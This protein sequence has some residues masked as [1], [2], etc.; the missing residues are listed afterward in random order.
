MKNL[1]L[2]MTLLLSAGVHAADKPNMIV[3][4]CDDLGYADVGFNGCKDIP[5]PNIDRIA[6]NG[7][8]CTSGYAPYSVCGPSRAGLITGRYGQRFGFERNP[9]YDPNN[10]IEGLPKEEK[11]FGE[12]LKPAGY[13]SG[14]VGKWHM[15]AHP[16]NHP[17][18]RGFD[19]F[20]GH[21]GGGHYY[22]PENLTIQDSYT[23]KAG[24][25]EV[26]STWTMKNHEA[27]PPRKYLTEEFSD[28]AVEFVATSKDKPFFLFLSYNAPHGPLQATEKYLSRFPNLEGNRQIYAAMVSA[29]DDGVGLL[30][31]KLDELKLTEDTIVFFMSDNGGAE[32]KYESDNGVLRGEKSSIWEG[33]FR[34]PYAVQWKG[35]LPAG[36]EYHKPVSSLD[37]MGT[38]VELAGAPVDPARPLDGVNLIPY[39]SGKNSG[40]PHEAIY[41]RKFDQDKYAIRKGDY[42][43]MIHFK[44]ANPTLYN[45]E[46]DIGEKNDIAGQ[47]PEKVQQLEQ[48]RKKWDSEL[49][50][51]QFPGAINSPEWQAQ[52]K[53]WKAEEAREKAAKRWDWFAALDADR[54]G[55]VTE[56]EWV[57]RETKSSGSATT[58][59]RQKHY[60]AERDLNGNGT[61]TR[62][63]LDASIMR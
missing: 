42:K 36:T 12:V 10:P 51:P 53:Q 31:D 6:K 57:D 16:S 22:L 30:L 25:E 47:H 37:V 58:L 48:M 24:W 56:K 35:V 27:I 43:L 7:V 29:V 32:R 45:L 4:L 59:E 2:G 19:Y 26:Y 28:A 3:V 18:N 33:G 9:Y 44:G 52:I 5:T 62:E 21:L 60:F 14:I 49:I 8:K 39:L 17:L 13:R 50:E 46:K 1:I 20:Y 61:I 34:V 40:T 54:D 38:I 23:P 11:T 63:E 55:L 41:L 15:G